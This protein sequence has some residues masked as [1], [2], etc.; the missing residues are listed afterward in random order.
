MLVLFSVSYL[1]SFSEKSDDI[2][3]FGLIVKDKG[4]H[5]IINDK[6]KMGKKKY[7]SVTHMCL[8]ICMSFTQIIIFT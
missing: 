8:S 5:K 1:W 3:L 6:D 2:N 7:N 4:F